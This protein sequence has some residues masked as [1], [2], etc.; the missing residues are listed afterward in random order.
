MTVLQNFAI[1]RLGSKDSKQPH[2]G[3]GK[4]FSSK[5]TD[6]SRNTQNW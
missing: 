6:I 2:K 5:I 3:F 4:D 1:A